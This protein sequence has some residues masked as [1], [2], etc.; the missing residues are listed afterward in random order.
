MR[1]LAVLSLIIV[2]TIVASTGVASAEEDMIETPAPKKDASGSRD[3]LVVESPRVAPEGVVRLQGSAGTSLDG[4]TAMGSTSATWSFLPRLSA[5]VGGRIESKS[6]APMAGVRFQV[7]DQET[8]CVNLTTSGAV[9]AWSMMENVGS[10]GE[11]RVAVGR[12]FGRFAA[13]INAAVGQGFGERRDTDGEGGAAMTFSVFPSLRIGAE[14]RARFE[15][16]DKDV[17]NVGRSY[18]AIGGGTA[19]ASFGS[20]QLQVLGG[21]MAPRGTIAP[22]PAVLAAAMVEF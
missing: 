1:G 4:A 19:Y 18:E 10:E 8:S 7:L 5:V 2:A 9:H 6:F 22:G 12:T 3:G 21:W 17:P 13:T 11:L 14:G 16:A 15:I 20:M